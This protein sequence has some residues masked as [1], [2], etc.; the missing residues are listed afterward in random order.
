MSLKDDLSDEGEEENDTLQQKTII[1]ADVRQKVEADK[2][3]NGGSVMI[4]TQN[5]FED[6]FKVTQTYCD[7]VIARLIR[8]CW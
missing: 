7:E 6:V 1:G 2:L 3:N 5:S 8:K 4:E